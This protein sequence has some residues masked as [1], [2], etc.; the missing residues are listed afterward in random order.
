MALFS[1][2]GKEFVD[3]ADDA[4][5]LDKMKEAGYQPYMAYTSNGKDYVTL[6]AEVKNDKLMKEAG[7]KS[8][9]EWE[10]Y[11]QIQ[12][13][14]KVKYSG[15]EAFG[16]GLLE[17]ATMGFSDEL[18]AFMAKGSYNKNLEAQRYLQKQAEEQ[19]PTAKMA[20]EVTGALVAGAMAPAA[21]GAK[22][23]SQAVGKGMLSGGIQ[24]ALQSYGESEE[25]SLAGQAK[26][27]AKGALTGAALGGIGGALTKPAESAAKLGQLAEAT[28]EAVQPVTKAAKSAVELGVSAGK[29]GAAEAQ[30]YWPVGLVPGIG[31]PAMGGIFAKGA[32]TDLVDNVKAGKQFSTF[33]RTLREDLGESA[34]KLDDSTIFNS[35]LIQPGDNAA[36]RFLADMIGKERGLKSAQVDELHKYFVEAPELSRSARRWNL[37]ERADEV[38]TELKDVARNAQK[39]ASRHFEEAEQL[40]K[41]RFPQQDTAI[42][43]E[44]ANALQYMDKKALSGSAR[45]AIESAF[46]ELHDDAT[47][48]GKL[49]IRDSAVQNQAEKVW[50]SLSPSEQYD[51]YKAARDVL[52]ASIPNPKKVPIS[53][54]NQGQKKNLELV[55]AINGKMNE[56]EEK[57]AANAQYSAWKG[58]KDLMED[59]ELFGE[60]YSASKIRSLLGDTNAGKQLQLNINKLQTQIEEANLPESQV[61]PLLDTIEKLRDFKQAIVGQNDL[62][63]TMSEIKS[64]DEATLRRLDRLVGKGSLASEVLRSPGQYT[65]A[66]QSLQQEFEQLAQTKFQKSFNDLSQR[67]K[68]Q[69]MGQQLK[70]VKK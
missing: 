1:K 49:D 14:S 46:H 62:S 23:V 58:I 61:K 31:K 66:Q 54:W 69:I 32:I 48:M 64:L 4:G 13:D 41:Q 67:E 24:N 45:E 16:Q 12:K 40:A 63:K 43:D 3:I 26:D 5:D 56:V 6:P 7:Y 20:G 25:T 34:R 50:D 17:Q 30:K 10:Q 38:S 47:R 19:Q 70:G 59:K 51:R 2:D 27:V 9:S 28:S 21:T 55:K 22:T 15:T 33:V 44:L 52:Q 35:Y 42:Q 65:A 11:Q 18:A 29:A 68:L 57:V 39:E 53:E 36:K 8:K 37:V 60:D